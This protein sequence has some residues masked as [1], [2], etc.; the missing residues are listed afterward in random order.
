MTREKLPSNG[1]EGGIR[2]GVTTAE[3][4]VGAGAEMGLP[5]KKASRRRPYL[6]QN[7]SRRVRRRGRSGRKR[8]A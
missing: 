1:G 6:R 3:L 2:R 5:A 4:L 8:K 7:L